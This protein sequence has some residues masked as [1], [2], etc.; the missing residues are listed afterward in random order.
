MSKNL[1]LSSSNEGYVSKLSTSLD[2]D[3]D[4]NFKK[5]LDVALKDD[6]LELVQRILWTELLWKVKEYD[7]D[8]E[9]H[10]FDDVYSEAYFELLWNLAFD[11]EKLKEK[12]DIIKFIKDD[13]KHKGNWFQKIKKSMELKYHSEIDYSII[14]YNSKQVENILVNSTN[15]PL[16]KLLEEELESKK[17]IFNFL[18]KNQKKFFD[19]YVLEGLDIEEI[20]SITKWKKPEI[21]KIKEA[22]LKKMKHPKSYSNWVI[23]DFRELSD[24]IKSLKADER[25]YDNIANK[26]RYWW[27]SDFDTAYFKSGNLKK[28]LEKFRK[29]LWIAWDVPFSF[30]SLELDN[31]LNTV[32]ETTNWVKVNL[33]KYM[34]LFRHY[35]YGQDS[36]RSNYGAS[37]SLI[38]FMFEEA[39][40]Y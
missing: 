12:E 26:D 31:K 30:K 8:F 33:R 22:T 9:K 28:D 40:K 21:E 29:I 20:I 37:Q 38:N 6:N 19:L 11:K 18:S 25:F 4:K 36:D 1:T 13:I 7:I 35:T 14:P 32:I 5:Q 27:Q 10:N 34:V 15:N 16:V 2:I 39:K 24:Y 23:Y 17:K 3:N